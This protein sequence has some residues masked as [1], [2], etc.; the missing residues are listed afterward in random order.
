MLFK[1]TTVEP[2][3]SMVC[4]SSIMR[5]GVHRCPFEM[6]H[7]CCGEFIT[8][9]GCVGGELDAIRRC[10]SCHWISGMLDGGRNVLI[11]HAT[12]LV[13]IAPIR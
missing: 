13:M 10:K 4:A 12:T 2:T 7:C 5:A 3:V 1:F 9:S 8:R 6:S 11:Y